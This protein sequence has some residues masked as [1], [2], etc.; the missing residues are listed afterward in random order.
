MVTNRCR[1]WLLP[2]LLLLLLLL[3]CCCRRCCCYYYF[4]AAAADAT[5]TTTLLPPPLPLMLLLLLLL[6]CCCRCYFYYLYSDSCSSSCPYFLF[7][8]IQ[9]HIS[10]LRQVTLKNNPWFFSVHL[11]IWHYSISKQTTAASSYILANSF[12]TNNPTTHRC[13]YYILSDTGNVFK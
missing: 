11:G 10:L 5:T 1:G 7:R 3:F 13:C 9:I 4:V 2:L 8:R 12:V 6:L